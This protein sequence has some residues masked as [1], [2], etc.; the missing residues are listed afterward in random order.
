MSFFVKYFQNTIVSPFVS[1]QSGL[2]EF[3]D[4][5]NILEDEIFEEDNDDSEAWSS[6]DSV[7]SVGEVS[8]IM[9]LKTIPL[10]VDQ[11]LVSRMAGR[12]YLGPKFRLKI[13]EESPHSTYQ[14]R[15]NIS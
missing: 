14:S 15:G 9:I 13:R 4:L 3:R 6:C 10:L 1:T 7:S 8:L 5:F 12:V 2:N 11:A